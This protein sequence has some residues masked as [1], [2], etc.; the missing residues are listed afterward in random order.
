MKVPFIDNVQDAHKFDQFLELFAPFYDWMHLDSNLPILEIVPSLPNTG[1]VLERYLKELQ[2]GLDHNFQPIF[3]VPSFELLDILSSNVKLTCAHT[4]P[5]SMQENQLGCSSTQYQ[6]FRHQ[7]IGMIVP[8]LPY[9][10]DYQQKLQGHNNYLW[11]ERINN[12]VQEL[13]N[14]NDLPKVKIFP[15]DIQY[16]KGGVKS[17]FFLG[18]INPKDLTSFPLILLRCPLKSIYEPCD[19]LSILPLGGVNNM[20]NNDLIRTSILD[21]FFTCQAVPAVMSAYSLD[22]FIPKPH[23]DQQTALRIARSQYALAH[24]LL[25]SRD[26]NNLGQLANI[27]SCSPCWFLWWNS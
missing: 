12:H 4:A 15:W 17:N 24:N 3:I 14:S 25:D 20:P 19:L 16:F 2:L 21:W 22:F 27:I 8:F 23:L 1:F 10:P 11:N 13:K 26:I 9:T 7:K 6:E 5:D 18:C